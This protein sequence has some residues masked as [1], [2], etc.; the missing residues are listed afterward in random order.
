MK[1]RPCGARINNSRPIRHKSPRY[2]RP[3]R[4]CWIN[5]L[6]K[7]IVFEDSSSNGGSG[8][9]IKKMAGYHQFHAVNVAVEETLRAAQELKAAETLGHYE[10][11]RKHGGGAGGRRGG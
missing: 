11:G 8:K 9:L 5:L 7:L 3:M 1:T 10:S 4:R 6:R 2:S